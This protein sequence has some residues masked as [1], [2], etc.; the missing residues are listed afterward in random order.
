MG[1]NVMLLLHTEGK[2]VWSWA[3]LASKAP[4]TVE[5]SAE[6]SG[7]FVGSTNLLLIHDSGRKYTKADVRVSDLSTRDEQA[8][9]TFEDLRWEMVDTRENPRFKVQL[10][11]VIRGVNESTGH[12]TPSEQVCVTEDLSL[13]G[14]LLK[15]SQGL[16]KGQLLEVRITLAPSQTVRMMGVVAHVDD[17]GTLIGVNFIDYVGAARYNLHQFLS[18]IAA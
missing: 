18:K 10:P 14:A 15:I 7:S 12:A 1:E 3:R 17:T 4:A 6:S 13:N 11:A 2:P 5:L 9:I 8:W 16:S